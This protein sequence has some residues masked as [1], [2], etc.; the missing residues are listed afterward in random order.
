[1]YCSVCGKE[2]VNNT[3]KCVQC[4]AN[5]P[6][7]NNK[8]APTPHIGQERN[9]DQDNPG[10]WFVFGLLFALFVSPLIGL[11]LWAVWKNET[12]NKAAAVGK[13]TLVGFGI[14]MGL[15]IVFM[16]VFFVFLLPMLIGGA[17]FWEFFNIFRSFPY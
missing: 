9:V 5:V 7:L 3:G 6:Y 13:G 4:G 11:I 14:S 2:V 16:I 15:A 8:A 1:M 12:P 17:M 10:N